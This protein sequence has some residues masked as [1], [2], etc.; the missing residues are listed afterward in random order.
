MGDNSFLNGMVQSVQHSGCSIFFI[1]SSVL[2]LINGKKNRQNSLANALKD[3]AF[4]SELQI[5]KEKYEDI[6]EAQEWAFKIWLKQQQRKY[7]QNEISKKL[8]NELL[9]EELKIFFRDWPLRIAI[10][11]INARRLAGNNCGLFLPMNIVIAKHNIGNAKDR[12][13]LLYPNL[14]DEVKDSLKK[15]GISDT[16][17]YRFKNE[18]T[19]RG[20]AA[21]ANI[22]AM[23]NSLPTVVI[24][25]TV[26]DKNNQLSIS[27]GCWN[28]D[29]LFPMQRKVIV[30]EYNA[31][32]MSNDKDYCESKFKEIRHVYVTIAAVLNDTY[33]LIENGLSP[34]YPSYAR[35]NEIAQFSPDLIDF[36]NNEYGSILEGVKSVRKLCDKANSEI[37]ISEITQSINSLK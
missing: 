28:Q 5:Q 20:G 7:A 10:E 32:R 27:I 2:S 30:L 18:T 33:S 15:L 24:I 23:M 4:Q 1:T 35:D 36:A 6:K 34:V 17:I 22:F 31:S 3:E 12:L 16:H 21:L 14:V 9:K 11:T 8:E 25:P 26:V 13:S 29:S 19:V 37:I